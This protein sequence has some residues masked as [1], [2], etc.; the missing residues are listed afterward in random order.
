[1]INVL[2]VNDIKEHTEDTT[3]ECSPTVEYEGSEILVIHNS[4]DGREALEQA[5]EI[6][7]GKKYD[8]TKERASNRNWWWRKL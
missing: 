8:R 5:E 7:K 6:L 4:Y 1:M 2:P 3:C